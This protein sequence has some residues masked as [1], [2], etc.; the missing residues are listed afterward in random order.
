M[1]LNQTYKNNI[2][3]NRKLSNYSWFNLVG[4]AEIFFK[5]DMLYWLI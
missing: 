3:F 2:S 5:A 4:P 1:K